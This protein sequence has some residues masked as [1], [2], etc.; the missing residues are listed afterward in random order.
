MRKTMIK[1]NQ[2]LTADL[3]AQ[4]PE[5]KFT[6][7][8]VKQKENETNKLKIEQLELEKKEL[9]AAMIVIVNPISKA[10]LIIKIKEK[11]QEIDKLK[12]QGQ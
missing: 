2:Q 6:K 11:Q 9:I 10:T 5:G 4:D 1:N 3:K 7:N 12:K 8:I